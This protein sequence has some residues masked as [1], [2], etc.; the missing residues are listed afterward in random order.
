MPLTNCLTHDRAELYGGL[1]PHGSR[2]F[3]LAF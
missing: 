3:S 1:M 2:K